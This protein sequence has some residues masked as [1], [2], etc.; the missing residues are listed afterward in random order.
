MKHTKGHFWF[1]LL[2][3]PDMVLLVPDLY[4]LC[5]QPVGSVHELDLQ[6]ARRHSYNKPVSQCVPSAQAIACFSVYI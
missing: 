3:S 6:L 1:V 5:Y 4:S 2:K